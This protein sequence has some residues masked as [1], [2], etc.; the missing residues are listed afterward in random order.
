[1]SLDRFSEHPIIREFLALDQRSQRQV[2]VLV[3]LANGGRFVTPD[4]ND[5]KYH[6][7]LR[8]RGLT[9]LEAGMIAPVVAA[10][11]GVHSNTVYR[12][13]KQAGIDCHV[14]ERRSG[15]TRPASQLLRGLR[16]HR[17]EAL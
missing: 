15:T 11:L 13:A 1:M 6:H 2:R 3:E 7:P 17:E 9:M 12:W 5:G 4:P 10:E 8:D 14:R 16:A